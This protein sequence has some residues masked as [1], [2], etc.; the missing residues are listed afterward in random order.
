MGGEFVEAR[1]RANGIESIVEDGDFHAWGSSGRYFSW[2]D[3]N[4]DCPGA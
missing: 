4:G 2:F 3:L 1:Q